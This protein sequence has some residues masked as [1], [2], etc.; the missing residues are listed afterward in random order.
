MLVFRNFDC[1]SM[2]VCSNTTPL[3]QHVKIRRAAFLRI[4]LIH[5]RLEYITVL[6]KMGILN[7]S[8]LAVVSKNKN[9]VTKNVLCSIVE[10]KVDKQI[11]L[12]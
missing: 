9:R 4:Q 5:G 12:R 6:G 2:F 7:S 1:L 3:K 10:W 11:S 8:A